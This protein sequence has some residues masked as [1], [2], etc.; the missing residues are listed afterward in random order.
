MQ[1]LT[2]AFLE[3]IKHGHYFAIGKC[4]YCSLKQA[5]YVKN[6]TMCKVQFELA[7]RGESIRPFGE[8]TSPMQLQIGYDWCEVWTK[9][10]V[11]ARGKFKGPGWYLTATDSMLI[12]PVGQFDMWNQ[13]FEDGDKFH[14]AVWNCP[15]YRT[16]YGVSVCSQHEQTLPPVRE[17]SRH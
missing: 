6:P 13:K 11:E 2:Q 12:V 7:L 17:D 15:F 10:E 5:E 3:H 16:V 4:L 8:E 1:D 9:A 14:V